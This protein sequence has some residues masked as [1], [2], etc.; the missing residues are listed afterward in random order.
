MMVAV[1]QIMGRRALRA[2]STYGRCPW[3]A[4]ACSTSTVFHSVSAAARYQM[5]AAGAISQVFK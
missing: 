1:L 2:S 4:D 5:M 3:A